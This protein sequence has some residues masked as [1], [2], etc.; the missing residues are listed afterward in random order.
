[1]FKILDNIYSKIMN[2][3]K[4][5][6]DITIDNILLSINEISNTE[7]L[8]SEINQYVKKINNGNNLLIKQLKIEKL[9]DSN[10]KINN[11]NNINNKYVLNIV[12]K[13]IIKSVL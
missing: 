10:K 9:M 4:K 3:K 12:E 11:I 13:Y 7:I 6:I 5:K 8:I 2:V 1:M